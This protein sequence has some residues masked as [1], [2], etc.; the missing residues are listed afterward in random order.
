MADFVVE[1]TNF[2]E[3]MSKAQARKSWQVYMDRSSCQTGGGAEVYTV[4]G[5]RV[6]I[7]HAIRLNFK[8]TN[9]ETEYEAMLAELA[10]TETSG[11]KEVEMKVDSQVVVGQVIGEYLAKGEKLKKSISIRCRK[12]AVVSNIFGSSG[13]LES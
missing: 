9:N 10:I 11:G 13:S 6:E 3:E 7:N 4:I 5:D 2:S 1:F 12:G 8:V